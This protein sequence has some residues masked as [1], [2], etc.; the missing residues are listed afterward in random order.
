MIVGIAVDTTVDSNDERAVTRS[1]AIVTAR[2]RAGSKRGAAEADIDRREYQRLRALESR[3]GGADEIKGRVVLITGA[4]RGIGR[5][6]A[7]A[8]AAAG[9]KV[10]L[11]GKTKKNLLEVQRELKDSGAPTVV[12]AADVSDEG[13]VSR[14]VAATEQQLGPVDVLVNNAGIF[15]LAPVE[16]MDARVFDR[17]LAVNLRGPFLMSRAVLPGMKSRK[18]GHI[19][20]ISS[21]AGRR[22]FAGGGAYCASKFGLAGLTEAMRYEARASNV[23]VTCVYPS[24]VNT[25]FVKK[26]G[27]DL[28]PERAIQPEDV[29][30]AVVSLVAMDDRAMTT[31]LEIW[32]TNP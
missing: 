11:L 22:G 5:A 3:S 8:F 13:V 23:R 14:A 29:A 25:D 6:L 28:A 12:L 19:V 21:T 32:Q 18:R 16:K 24:T 20:N 2:R 30:N 4:G 10:A 31:A 17:L 1:R 7:H 27:M 26:A 15:A 9:A